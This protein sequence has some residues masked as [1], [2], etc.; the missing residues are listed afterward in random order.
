MAG[1]GA[2]LEAFIQAVLALDPDILVGYD[3]RKVSLLGI[4]AALVLR[5]CCHCRHCNTPGTSPDS[6]LSLLVCA[7]L[8]SCPELQ[9][10]LGHEAGA[11]HEELP[12]ME[13]MS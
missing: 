12:T 1:E 11:E 5:Q 10:V 4:L 8:P 2:L 9:L 6:K 3:V 13:L 7:N